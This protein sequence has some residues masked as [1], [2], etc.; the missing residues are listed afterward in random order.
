M[1]KERKGLAVFLRWS[2]FQISSIIITPR[3]NPY[4]V[5]FYTAIA[6][7]VISA[8]AIIYFCPSLLSTLLRVVNFLLFF[9][10]QYLSIMELV[11]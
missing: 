5:N 10:S 3:L 2:T 1:V 7:V 11:A 8:L 4:R 9:G 6:L